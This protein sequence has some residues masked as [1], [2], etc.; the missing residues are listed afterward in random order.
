M[1]RMNRRDK[2]KQEW[3]EAKNVRRCDLIDREID[4]GLTPAETAELQRLQAEML[5]YRHKVAPLP[6][7]DA[8]RLHR[9][10]LAQARKRFK[11]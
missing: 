5:K 4:A 7:E 10:L 6:L 2:G 11:G 9:E 8:R 3:T 1:K